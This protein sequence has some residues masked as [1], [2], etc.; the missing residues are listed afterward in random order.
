MI[1]IE[2]RQNQFS[3]INDREHVGD[4]LGTFALF[5]VE[6]ELFHTVVEQRVTRGTD[7]RKFG[8]KL[9]FLFV[10]FDFLKKYFINFIRKG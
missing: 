3:L 2:L 5:G 6:S 7:K 1:K 4:S 8:S 9:F 10:F